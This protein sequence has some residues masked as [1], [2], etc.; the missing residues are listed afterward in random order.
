M[1]FDAQQVRLF[2]ASFFIKYQIRRG[3]APL[4]A[5]AP[6]INGVRGHQPPS[7]IIQKT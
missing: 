3:G 2:L 5:A 7:T 6:I 4:G 1:F